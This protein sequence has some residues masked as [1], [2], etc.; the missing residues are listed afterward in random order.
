[1]NITIKKMSNDECQLSLLVQGVWISWTAKVSLGNTNSIGIGLYQRKIRAEN[2]LRILIDRFCQIPETS[3]LKDGKKI[4]KSVLGERD[5]NA[6]MQVEKWTKQ[7]ALDRH[8]A[9][10]K[11]R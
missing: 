8:I 9:K 2:L 10:L 5:F 11:G 3:T 6:C 7:L 4:L 1:M